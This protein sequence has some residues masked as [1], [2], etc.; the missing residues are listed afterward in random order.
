M[1]FFQIIWSKGYPCLISGT[2]AKVQINH[3][4]ENRILARNDWEYFMFKQKGKHALA[5]L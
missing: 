5:H 2:K 1:F 3:L 4:D